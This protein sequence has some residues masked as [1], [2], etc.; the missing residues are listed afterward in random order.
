MAKLIPSCGK[1][2]KLAVMISRLLHQHQS[3]K[4]KGSS[5]RHWIDMALQC[6]GQT[7]LWCAL[8]MVISSGR[9]VNCTAT[10]KNNDSSVIAVF[11]GRLGINRAVKNGLSGFET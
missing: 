6:E 8:Y 4:N 1:L 9:S 7:N 5:V 10:K 3:L 11:H 2:T